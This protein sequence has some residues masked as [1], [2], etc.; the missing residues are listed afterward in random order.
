MSQVV[1]VI[2]C[3]Y[4]RPERLALTLRELEAQVGV[5]PELYIWNNNPNIAAEVSAIVAKTT[6]QVTVYNSPENVGGFGRFYKARQ[7]ADTEPFIV[8]IDDDA[9]V[10]P[11]ALRT[12]RDEICEG[13]Y[14]S[15]FAFN[16]NNPKDYFDRT[17]APNGG[18]ADYC[19]T[20]GSIIDS[21]VFTSPG[22]FDCPKQYWFMEDLW[23]SY[24]AQQ[25]LGWE[26][27]KSSADIQLDEGDFKDQ[28]LQL[29]AQKTEFL[30]YLIGHGYTISGGA[31]TEKTR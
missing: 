10:G 22:L 3:T 30:E 6:L 17:A 24:Y 28:W 18:A 21:C 19:G 15:F 11:T 13:S 4:N 12:M 31:A 5:I 9:S 25:V 16:L 23:L 29:K 7:L 27:R 8:M 26:L 1:P 2:L 14:Q 20:G